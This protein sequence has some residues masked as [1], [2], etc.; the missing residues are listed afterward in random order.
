MTCTRKA[1][2]LALLCLPLGLAA[3]M[4]T[5]QL[6]G[7]VRDASGAAVPGAQ[8]EITNI[9]TN[10]ARTIPT[11]D[12]GSY[13]FVNLVV[14]TYTLRVTQQGFETYVQTGIVVNVNSN[15]TINVDLKIGTVSQQVEVQASAPMVETQN[16][17][18]GQVINQA[19]VVEMPL[20]GRQVTQLI[21]LSGAATGAPPSVS[22]SRGSLD[23]PTV[24][25]F[26]IA[27]SQEDQTMY[28]LDGAPNMDMRENAGL[29]LPFPDTIGEF[30]V[31][32]SALPAN[33]GGLPG[34]AV[35][36]VTRS[37]TNSFHGNAFE[38]LRNGDLDAR[39][40]FAA[41]RDSL[42]RNQFGGTLGGPVLKDKLFF[43]GGV[44]RTTERTAPATSVATVPTA[45]VLAGNF[46]TFI[47][48]TCRAKA[49]KLSSSVATNNIL[50]PGEQNAIGMK[51][52]AEL[53]VG[54]APCGVVHYGVTTD[55]NE[56]QG[57]ARVDWHQSA[58][59]SVFART[60]ISDLSLPAYHDP[61]T[62][63]GAADGLSDRIT[64]VVAG[65][66]YTLGPSAVSSFILSFDRSST[67]RL[68]PPGLL[69]P[70]QLGINVTALIAG[71]PDSLSASGYGG[72]GQVIPA[73]DIENT[74]VGSENFNLTRG[75]H[76]FIMGGVWVLTQMNAL[77]PAHSNGSFT[78]NGLLTGDA[79]ADLMTGN[80]DG[81]LQGNPQIGRE[82]QLNPS[83][84]IQDFWKVSPRF[85]VNLGLRWDPF[86]P[87]KNRYNQASDFS[88][89]GFTAGT[90]SKVFPNAPPGLTF[91]G[92]TGW[93][94]ATGVFPRYNEFTPRIGIVW[95][96]AGTGKESIRAGYGIFDGGTSYFWQRM[97]VLSNAPWG[98]TIGL[99]D[100]PGGIANPWLGYPGGNPF[101]T[102]NP[103]AS[104]KFPVGGTYTFYPTHP[105]ATAIQQW[106]V[107]FQRQFAG[108]WLVSA[109]YLGN[110]T[111][112]Q[113]LGTEI[114]HAVYGPG[115]TVANQNQR[116]VLYL[117][118]PATGQY[119]GS[120]GE[121][122][123]GGT[124]N[125]NGL[126][127][128]LNHRLS[129]N[130]SLISNF[131]WSHCLNEGTEGQDITDV[132]QNPS[133]PKGDYGNCST[134]KRRLF[135]LSLIGDSPK[136]ESRLTRAILGNWQGSAI[137]TIQSGDWIA[138]TDG[139]DVSLTG[140]GRDR[141][142]TVGNPFASGN[143]AACSGPSAVR[144]IAH[145]FNPCAYATQATGTYGNTGRDT[146][147]G[148]GTWNLD[149]GFSRA[150]PITERV[151]LTFRA[152]AFNSLNHT[153]LGDPTA[154]LNSSFFGQITT[155]RDPR[156]M[157]GALVLNF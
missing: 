106:N 28:F 42:K 57:V 100:P 53:P 101:P 60:F 108:N 69:T 97:H 118:N 157:Q 103:T 49:E 83:L 15:F 45:A 23:Y 85:Q 86:L 26:S 55:D 128:A 111:T 135:N 61:S 79:M 2:G 145:W 52:L 88:L 89:A 59:N 78:F 140:V 10:A 37:G 102:G 150:F 4:T 148:P 21:A 122:Y 72:P 8:V 36:A 87:S 56:S 9:G 124:S 95:D 6:T 152:E 107:S 120:V 109:T 25:T 3:Q 141:P 66:T 142:N 136:F 96:P 48:T 7:V 63:L 38:F 34:G 137:F 146:L 154:A 46:Q 39:N 75:K 62:I 50:N 64:T 139:T 94:G 114:D 12:S 76:Q 14:G 131:T 16:T 71:F 31:E 125:Y 27:G 11:D 40:Y 116:R 65:D 47:S 70:T 99:T 54:P 104:Y 98:A 67:H 82:S 119:Y 24:A 22:V 29:P 112:H 123:D 132:F 126:L 153:E 44:Q 117:A 113:W 115:A 32:T 17:S 127:L 110:E 1:I 77:E 20:N 105:H 35:N 18:V 147:L 74:F 143:V 84:F 134:D 156:I 90:V 41:T 68:D 130:F 19:S 80:L 91:P 58:N 92:D 33:Y 5:S 144:T 155:A 73:T 43:F 81:Y 13:T 51:V 93:P 138:V 151:K 133:N 30:K 121:M 129:D 149:L